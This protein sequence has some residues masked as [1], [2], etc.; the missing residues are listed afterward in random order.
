M[1]IATHSRTGRRYLTAGAATAI[2]VGL[3]LAGCGNDE[4]EPQSDAP[5]APSIDIHRAPDI[6][7]WTTAGSIAVHWA[8]WTVRPRPQ[9]TVHRLHTDPQGAA[10]AAIDQSVQLATAVDGRWA[11]ILPAVTVPGQGRDL[12]AGNRALV[13]TSGIDPSVA[14]R[15]SGT[16]SRSTRPM[17]PTSRSSSASPTTRWPRL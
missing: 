8:Q 1:T 7:S 10:L 13:S 14:P 6:A 9:G 15:S 5:A 17:P 2:T 12:W 3:L 4:T 11:E 16:R